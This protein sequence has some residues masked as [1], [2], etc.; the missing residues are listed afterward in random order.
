[1]L[2]LLEKIVKLTRKHRERDIFKINEVYQPLLL[3]CDCANYI[4]HQI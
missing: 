1:M 2:S 4:Y 3:R